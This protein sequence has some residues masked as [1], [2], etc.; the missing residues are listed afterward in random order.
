M[1]QNKNQRTYNR[2]T[3]YYKQS[4]NNDMNPNTNPNINPNTNPNTNPNYKKPYTNNKYLKQP[5]YNQPNYNQSNYNQSNNNNQPNY[6]QPNNNQ[7]NN[8]Q[9]NNNQS[10]NNQPNN[11][12]SN[13]NQSNNNQQ[14]INK[15]NSN[16]SNSN[17]S[18]YKPN[19]NQVNDTKREILI[20]DEISNELKIELLDYLYSNIELYQLRYTI[21]KTIDNAQILK[22][23]PYH[24]TVHFHGYNYILIIKKLS[25]NK[26]G[27]YMIYKMDL[28]FD[29]VDIDYNQIK[30]Y[31]LNPDIDNQNIIDKYNNTIIDGKLVFKKEQK[32][33]LINDILY[34][35]SEK[36]LTI[37]IE[38]KFKRIDNEIKDLNKLIGSHFD[39]KLIKLYKYTDMEDLIYNK[40]KIS[41]FKINGL[42][43]LPYRSGRTFIYLNDSEFDNI[44]NSPNLEMLSDAIN[45]KLPP[46]INMIDRELLLQKT[47]IIDVYEV[48]TPDKTGRFGIA[49]VPTIY[50]SHK[51][52]SYFTLNDQLIIKCTFDNKFSKW[53]PLL[54]QLLY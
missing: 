16:Q 29:K 42:I 30:I 53:K 20:G 12:Q 38:D 41:D 3:N 9:S 34:Y 21:L 17:Q 10:N 35:Q 36:L 11:N 32:L 27:F 8:N 37:K 52:R 15:P 33:F 5:N 6:N 18:N 49:A 54:E 45:I 43:F 48:F 1:N 26:L 24:I 44:K 28:K 14:N 50:M 22:Q 31:S 25:D 46:N 2:G 47:R 7:S 40:I 51:L 39:I 13:Y 23:Q 4:N 19:Y